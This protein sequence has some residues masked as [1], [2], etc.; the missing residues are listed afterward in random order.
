MGN[1]L[2]GVSLSELKNRPGMHINF[3][4]SDPKSNLIYRNFKILKKEA[5]EKK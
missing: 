1:K 2:Q 4:K 3:I 5:L